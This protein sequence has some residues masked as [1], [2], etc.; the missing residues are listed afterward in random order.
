MPLAIVAGMPKNQARRF[1]QQIVETGTYREWDLRWV[2]SRRNQADL[3]SCWDQ[4]VSIADAASESGA[5][6]FAYHKATGQRDQYER[7]VL[8]RHRLVWLDHRS[9]FDSESD[10]WLLDIKERLQLEDVWREDVRPRHY[11]HALILPSEKFTPHRKF[12]VSY[13]PWTLAQRADTKRKIS[14]ARSAIDEF[15]ERHKHKDGWRDEQGLIFAS[16]GPFHGKPTLRLRWKFT[17]KLQSGFHFDV[18]HEKGRS[19]A[20][21]TDESGEMTSFKHTNVDAHGHVR[22]GQ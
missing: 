6:I 13:N 21:E 19:F 20:M 3:S 2:P 17:H 10:Q 8:F 15:E 18:K 5:H 9:I 11:S 1:K 16:R 4:A 12:A 7:E 22:G 14:H